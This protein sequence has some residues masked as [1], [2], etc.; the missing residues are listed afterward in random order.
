M[1]A[2]GDECVSGTFI[3]SLKSEKFEIKFNFAAGQKPTF[4]AKILSAGPNSIVVLS[5]PTVT[6]LAAQVSFQITSDLSKKLIIS[7]LAPAPPAPLV[8]H[9]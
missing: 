8:L 2:T 3:I 7:I 9:H 6:G 5:G 4:N 1:Q